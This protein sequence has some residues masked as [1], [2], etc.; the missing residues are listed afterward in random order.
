MSAMDIDQAPYNSELEKQLFESL[1]NGT[2]Q[3]ATRVKPS[4]PR[5]KP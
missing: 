2:V 1:T 5:S 4:A 3:K